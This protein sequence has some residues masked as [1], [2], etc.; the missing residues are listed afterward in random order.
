MCIRDR[1]QSQRTRYK[2]RSWSEAERK[3]KAKVSALSDEEVERLEALGVSWDPLAAQWERM[4]G[5][6]AA[7]REREGHANV[8]DSH[9][10]DGERLGGWVRE[11]RKRYKA[12]SWSEAERKG[13]RL[14]ALSDEEVER[15]EALGVLWSRSL[16]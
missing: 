7:Y 13:K 4:Y 16:K 9:M 11:Q 3:G 15:L 5:L 12:R 14:S 6:L 1:L 8:P 2:A 10:E